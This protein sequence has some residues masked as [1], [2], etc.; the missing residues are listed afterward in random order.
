MGSIY[1]FQHPE[2][3]QIDIEQAFAYS[4]ETRIYCKIGAYM[5]GWGKMETNVQYTVFVADIANY[6][7]RMYRG[8]KFIN[9]DAIP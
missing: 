9:P 2:L 1:N 7:P 4:D 8:S 3:D 6:I 5:D